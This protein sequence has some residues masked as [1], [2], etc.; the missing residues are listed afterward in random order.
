[1][2]GERT[3]AA[4]PKRL[5]TLRGDGSYA[6]SQELGPAIG[7]L[8]ALLI[9]QS[10]ASKAVAN[11]QDLLVGTYTDLGKLGRADTVD[12][13]WAAQTVGKLGNAWLGSVMPL[14]VALPALAIVVGLAQSRGLVTFKVL[15]RP[16]SLNPLAGVK[17]LISMQAWVQLARSLFKVIVVGAVTWRGLQETATQLPQVDGT[18]DPRILL[19][20]I[21]A[22]VLNIGMPVAE[23]LLALSLADYGYQRWHFARSSR[24]SRDDVKDEAKQSEG[25]PQV[26]AKI[27]AKQRQMA[28]RRRQLE[29]VPKASVVITNPTHIAVALQYEASMSS[30][31]VLAVGADL[32]AEK[33]K[34]AARIA[35]VPLVENVPLA[36]GLYKA[37]DVGDEI[38]VELYGAVAEVLAYVYNLKRRRR[39]P[40]PRPRVARPA[41][42]Y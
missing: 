1:M 2:S 22:A 38:P 13:G 4:T 29:D 10:W 12:L 11:M 39:R 37:V 6:K 30:P 5:S 32:V 21:G 18:G 9:L 42:R 3:E 31:K 15:Y 20:F 36:R 28:R 25:D 34:Q 14:V 24:M 16:G 23:T 8:V 26:K 40:D 27:R 33:I 35:G 17:R 41:A 19:G 7:L